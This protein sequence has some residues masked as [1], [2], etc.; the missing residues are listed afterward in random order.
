MLFSS[1]RVGELSHEMFDFDIF[2]S[3]YHSNN[4]FS[5]SC[6]I[7]TM[8]KIFPENGA[9]VS[10]MVSS[11]NAWLN[12]AFAYC[13]EKLRAMRCHLLASKIEIPVTTMLGTIHACPCLLGPEQKGN[14]TNMINIFRV[15]LPAIIYDTTSGRNA[16]CLL[17]AL[18]CIRRFWNSFRPADPKSKNTFLHVLRR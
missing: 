13:C 16:T 9:C 12:D 3:T 10:F 8:K 4:S 2:Y 18:H 14:K 11:G 15:P 17:G 1:A 7:T 6:V 5:V